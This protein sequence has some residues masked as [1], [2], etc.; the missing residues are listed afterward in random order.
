MLCKFFKVVMD[1]LNMSKYI[2]FKVRKICRKWRD[3]KRKYET[4][5][6]W[7]LEAHTF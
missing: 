2:L 4:L 7:D 5:L 6:Q 1:A 3:A